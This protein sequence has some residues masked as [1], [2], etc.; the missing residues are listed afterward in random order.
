[1]EDIEDYYTYY[2]M[3]LGI[4]EDVFWHSDMQFL[5]SVAENNSAYENW[6]NW[7]REEMMKDGKK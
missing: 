4:S 3:I 7:A 2:V 5:F 6:I 1:M